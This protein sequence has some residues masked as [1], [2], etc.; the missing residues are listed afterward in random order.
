[1]SENA[2]KA[3][4]KLGFKKSKCGAIPE[5]GELPYNDETFDIIHCSHV[6]EHL[7][8]P[9][10]VLIEAKRILKPGGLLIIA[11]PNIASWIGRILIL[12]GYQ[13][14]G[15][16]VSTLYP[17]SGKGL[18]G[19][20]MFGDGGTRGGFWDLDIYIDG[21]TAQR[22]TGWTQ[23]PGTIDTYQASVTDSGITFT[24]N[25]TEIAP[26]NGVD[27]LT[28]RGT[29]TY[30]VTCDSDSTIPAVH[31]VD[32]VNTQ[33]RSLSVDAFSIITDEV[34]L[35]NGP[36]PPGFH[37]IDNAELSAAFGAGWQELSNAQFSHNLAFV[38]N[39]TTPSDV[40]FEIAGSNKR[41]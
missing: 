7:V 28:N 23:V 10:Q 22:V 41:L 15:Q 21:G 34:P 20:Y 30:T 6:I 19:K 16:E 14:F 17:L 25:T 11:T 8:N 12:F 1:M 13:G 36:L 2:I 4:K 9:D 29:K 37:D 5:N 27:T 35:A 26:N 39:T 32:I 31:V 33:G 38:S 18:L 3:A 40:S 24:C